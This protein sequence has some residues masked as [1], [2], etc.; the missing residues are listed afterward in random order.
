[1]NK[2]NCAL[3]LVDEII[4]YYDARSKEHQ[5][6]LYMFRTNNCSSSGGYFCTCSIH[7]FT[8]HVWDVQLLIRCDWNETCR[9]QFNYSKLIRKS[10]HLVGHSHIYVSRCTVR[11]CKVTHTE[12]VRV[13]IFAIEKLSVTYSECVSVIQHAMRM[14]SIILSCVAPSSFQIISQTERFQGKR[15][16]KQDACFDFL[17]KF[18]L[19]HLAF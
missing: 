4:L 12:R 18:C 9:G 11:E 3:K 8:M 17:Y 16:R 10:V 7:Y 14:R 13:T 15:Y 5:N 19:Q 6:I 1:M 2:E